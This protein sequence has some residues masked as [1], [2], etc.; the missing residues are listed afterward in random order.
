MHKNKHMQ[1]GASES[2]GATP[3]TVPAAAAERERLE[4]AAARR[5]A[6]RARAYIALVMV[7]LAA[8]L[9]AATYAW[10]TSK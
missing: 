8:T 9:G 4:P 5:H 1:V 2:A 10:F 6:R 7:A 3:G